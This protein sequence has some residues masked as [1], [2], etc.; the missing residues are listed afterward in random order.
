[1][2]GDDWPENDT[3]Y[4][5]TPSLG[6]KKEKK[7]KEITEESTAS[8][9]A[10]V[11]SAR[12]GDQFCTRELGGSARGLSGQCC[13]FFCRQRCQ[14]VGSCWFSFGICLDV[15]LCILYVLM[16]DCF[17]YLYSLFLSS[18]ISFLFGLFVCWI[19]LVR[20]LNI[21]RSEGRLRNFI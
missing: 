14:S 13:A 3:N 15:L 10:C 11:C 12:H 7:K 6:Q 2:T 19:C 5:D 9:A 20:C 8:Y 18:F 4:Y 16:L 21:L 1:M 17:F